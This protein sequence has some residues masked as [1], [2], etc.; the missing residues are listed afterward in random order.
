[1]RLL[2]IALLALLLAPGAPDAGGAEPPSLRE[3]IDD[4]LDR[5]ADWLARQQKP[6]GSWP[7]YERQYPMGPTALSLFALRTCSFPG[8]SS[9]LDRGFT[10]LRRLYREA[11][12][13]KRLK[14][15]SV[16]LAI[17]A[18]EEHHANPRPAPKRDRYGEHHVKVP[19]RDL[20]W[21]REMTAWLVSK[22]QPYG[23]WRYPHGGYDYSNTQYALLAL[24][25]SRR[26]GIPVPRQVFLDAMLH[27][28]ENQAKDGPVVEQIPA[29]PR[30]QRDGERPSVA[31]VRARA[32]AGDTRPGR[33]S[34]GR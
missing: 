22:Q 3:R 24:K 9:V 34:P 14:T 20:G 21:M 15:Y 18:L 17:L 23:V 25:A 10:R 19:L 30:P 28:V 32:R 6:D 29:A 8:S 4:S 16:A 5:G 26:C 33:S 1:M 12:D 2:P 13:E 31:P 7:G 11:R 27:L